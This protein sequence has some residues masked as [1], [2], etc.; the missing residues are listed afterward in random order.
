MG[1]DPE[2]NAVAQS[3]VR[4]AVPQAR[5][6]PTL[7]ANFSNWDFLDIQSP[8][9]SAADGSVENF[10]TLRQPVNAWGLC[11]LGQAKRRLLFFPF[12]P[13]IWVVRSGAGSGSH[14]RRVM[15]KNWK[16]ERRE[17]LPSG[18]NRSGGQGSPPRH[19][20]SPPPLSAETRLFVR[21]LGGWPGGSN[22]FR[23]LSR[24]RLGDRDDRSPPPA[25]SS[26]PASGG[27]LAPPAG[28]ASD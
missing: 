23:H 8:N 18:S 21:G 4:E 25:G 7:G 6:T 22:G 2:L 13:K 20:T 28:I 27:R 19:R 3:P 11:E 10:A 26:G 9:R 15:R 17:G 16:T 1:N 5:R 14:G 12:F 24:R